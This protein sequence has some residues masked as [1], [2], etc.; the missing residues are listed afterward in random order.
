MHDRMHVMLGEARAPFAGVS[1][2]PAM[3][4]FADASSTQ[5]AMDQ[6]FTEL[7]SAWI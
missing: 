2:Q 5:F 6:E 1:S 3:T 4:S 7:L